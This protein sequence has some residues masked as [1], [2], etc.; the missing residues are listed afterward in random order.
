MKKIYLIGVFAFAMASVSFGQENVNSPDKI[1]LG[2]KAS[3]N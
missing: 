3:I 1:H 2:I